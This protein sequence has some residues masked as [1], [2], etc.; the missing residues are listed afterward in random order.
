MEENG[1][2]EKSG[3]RQAGRLSDSG[4]DELLEELRPVEPPPFYTE[5]LLARVREAA[6][7]PSWTERLRSPALAWSVAG[8]AVVALVLI[9]MNSGRVRP[10]AVIVAPGVGVAQASI[11]PVTPA[12]NA[13]VGSGDVEIVA[14]IYPPVEEGTIRLYV[15]EIDVTGLAEVTGSYVMYSPAERLE[16]GEH[17]ITI[18][19][20]DS[21]G[22]SISDVSWLFY[23]LNGEKQ[24]AD[25]S[26]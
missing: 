2:E 19:I 9:V 11:D 16:E 3:R 23:A 13:V 18:E 21:A 8:A 26:V 17:I 10:P 14:G 4:V 7:R 15:D 5:R 20:R 12:D 22:R 25:D 6:K 24:V 1:R